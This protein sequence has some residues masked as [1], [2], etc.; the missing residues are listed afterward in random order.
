MSD[1]FQ[2]QNDPDYLIANQ[3]QDSGNLSSRI[4]IHQKFSTGA[5]P[6]YDFVLELA[7]IK[8]GMKILEIGSG[9]SAL[10][11]GSVNRQPDS[12]FFVLSD[13]SPGMALDGKRNLRDDRRF[14][15]V[16]MN[17]M[18]A[19][20]KSGSFD[21]VIANHMLYHV[22]SV[23]QVLSEVTRLMKTNAVFMAATNGPEHM[24]DLDQLQEKFSQ[25]LVGK[26]GMSSRFNLVNG[27]KQLREFF[28]NIE[29]HIYP[30]DLW[31]T[32]AALLTN[33]SYSTPIVK[34]NLGDKGKAEM[35]AFYKRR[36]DHYGGIMI[37]K[38]TGIFIARFS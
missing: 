37:R 22:P 33:Y 12:A 2:L 8:P 19:S 4:L 17:S 34:E 20:F 29:L 16:A 30:S 35:T 31:V 11:R 38:E 27:E 7:K 28:G 1:L 36:I 32:D 18:A 26:H 14:G 13:L 25:K 21:L 23:S 10:W 24:A 15:F 9:S 6:W 3:Y 5:Q